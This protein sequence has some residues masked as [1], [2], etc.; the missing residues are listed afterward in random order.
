MTTLRNEIFEKTV[1]AHCVASASGIMYSKSN[2]KAVTYCTILGPNGVGGLLKAFLNNLLR[3][4]RKD[5]FFAY[6]TV[7]ICF[8]TQSDIEKICHAKQGFV[9]V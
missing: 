9:S 8:F 4:M 1:L 5:Y 2:G 6:K 3:N 7:N